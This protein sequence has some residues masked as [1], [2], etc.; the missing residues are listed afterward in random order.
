VIA[1]LQLQDGSADLGTVNFVF[2]TGTSVLPLNENFDGV[3][4]PALPAGWVA[5]VASGLATN[6]WR[7]VTTTPDTA[8]N[9]AFV[10]DPSTIHDISLDTPVFMVTSTN[11]QLSF[12]NNYATESGF[13]GGVLEISIN[14]GPFTDILAAGGSFV[15]G[16]Y[17]RTISPSFSNPL[18]GRQAW[19]GS[20]GGYL[21]TTANLPASAAGAS[22]QLRF[23]MGS[24]S[25]VSS[26]GWRVDTVEV[27][28]GYTCAANAAPAV[29]A[30]PATQ[31]VQYSDPISPVSITAT[32]AALDIPLEISTQ[33]QF[34][35]GSFAPGLPAG[36]SLAANG[37]SAAG[38][39]GTCGWTLSGTALTAP[40]T[41]VVRATASD[42]SGGSSSTDITI[43][44]TQEDARAFYS[45]V[46]FASTGSSTSSTADVVLAATVMDISVTADAGGDTYPGDIRNANVTFVDRDHG[47]AILCTANV[48][49]IN[50]ND[51]QSGTASCNTTVNLGN[52]NSLTLRVGIIV[53]NYYTRNDPT[54][55]GL[56]TV[57]KAIG[58]EFVTGGGYLT[59]TDSAGLKAGDSGSK[60]NFGL[61]VKYN[62]GGRNL[63]GHVNI[64]VRRTEA[65]GSLHVYQVKGNALTSLTVNAATGQAVFT[66]RASI[67]DVTDP[68]NTIS[69]DGN[70][71]I[72]FVMTDLGEPGSSDTIGITV[73]NK[74]GGLWFSSHWDSTKTIEQLLGGGNLIVH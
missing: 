23:R 21:T 36:L 69:V 16:G 13:D 26:T 45:G 5:T 43:Q 52:A 39:V 60:N 29:T 57:S 15:T 48:G 4:A 6:N 31:S 73:W 70:A 20:S 74:N 40:G 44:V 67:Q 66:G 56:V 2:K 42:G 49:L 50:P 30:S 3:S 8:P 47:N 53:G 9:T 46:L 10:P 54:E 62:R 25:S 7:T 17:N 51:L 19:S 35:G 37:C 24:D 68:N 61:D 11:A 64:I 38:N 27:F 28:D 18:A 1:T 72:Q 41:Y 14:G 58:T 32:D 33:W 63:R 22:V 71:T 12:R 34:N 65:D 55:D 59:L